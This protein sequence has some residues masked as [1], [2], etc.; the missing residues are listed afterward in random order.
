MT[1]RRFALLV[2]A[3]AVV[4]AAVS[5]LLR[6]R[7]V[8]DTPE[9]GGGD[10][11]ATA[12]A[13]GREEAAAAHILV[14]HAESRPLQPGVSRSRAEAR[15][16]AARIAAL[17]QGKAGSFEEL[18]R[19]YSDDPNVERNSGYLGIFK[20]DQLPLALE[21]PLFDLEVGHFNPLVET[22]RGYHLLMRLP[23]RRA[24]ARHILIT[25]AGARGAPAG[26]RRSRA[27]AE[28]IAAEVSA[29]SRTG[30]VD[31]CELAAR[32]SD[33]AENRFQCGLIGLVEPARLPR[34]L[35]TELFALAPGEVSEVVETEFGFHLIKRDGR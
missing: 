25:W 31:F 3:L 10:E 2:F 24:V 28:M 12:V 7:D 27:Q 29:M 4:G 1:A 6:Q 33:D 18:A 16:R 8:A 14:A 21:V 22:E 19:Q 26:V 11:A 17:V 35:E 30:E 23:V 20:R 9:P 13:P 32:F 34:T 15:E 5:G